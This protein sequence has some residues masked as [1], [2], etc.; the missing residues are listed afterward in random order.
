MRIG[1]F[2]KLT[3]VDFPGL[4]AATVFTQGCNFRCGYC[5][6]P[7]LV[8]PELFDKPLLPEMVLSYL[9]GRQ[10]K[11]EGVVITG[12]EPTLQKGLVDFIS[13]IKELGFAVKLDTNGSHPEVLFTLFDL[14]LIDYVALD[15][16][17]SPAKYAQVT[18]IDCDMAKIQ[19][20]IELIINSG[21][22]YQL[23][24]TL[25]KEQCSEKDLVEIQHLMPQ[26]DHYVLQPFV[27][28]QKMVDDRFDHQDQYTISEVELLK[29]KYD[30]NT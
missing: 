13:R 9:N 26:A 1:G 10:G 18:G 12:G 4:I 14:N 22:R 28:S 8:L 20:S 17:S 30:K 19:E 29:A 2:Q 21:V 27:L 16:K 23:R 6:N 7:Q 25:V 11:L 5:H 15:I 3:L 24:T